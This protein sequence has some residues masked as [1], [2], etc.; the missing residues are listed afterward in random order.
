MANKRATH[1]SRLEAFKSKRPLV[2]ASSKYALNLSHLCIASQR[3][4]HCGRR[5]THSA[6]LLPAHRSHVTP[7]CAHHQRATHLARHPKPNSPFGSYYRTSPLCFRCAPNAHNGIPRYPQVGR[8]FLPRGNDIVTRRPLVLQLI[9]TAP[10]PAGRPAEWGE[11]LH[12]P[13]KMFYDFDKIRCGRGAPMTAILVCII[14]YNYHNTCICA[15]YKPCNVSPK[16]VHTLMDKSLPAEPE[17]FTS[18]RWGRSVLDA[19]P[20]LQHMLLAYITLWWGS[21]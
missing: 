19:F 12:A 10:S 13:G 4:Y 6:T 20:S 18:M 9:K 5:A 8:D 17:H 21:G 16:H 7:P 2:D 3:L 1:T 11:F 14:L 15:R